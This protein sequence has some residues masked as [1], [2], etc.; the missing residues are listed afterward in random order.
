MKRIRSNVDFFALTDPGLARAQKPNEDA[1]LAC[2]LPEGHL[3]GVA[4]GMGGHKG[5]ARA[6][7]LALETVRRRL[8][9]AADSVLHEPTAL[10]LLDATEQAGR[11]VW[12]EASGELE[13][14]GCT[15]TLL[16]LDDHK[17]MV[18]QVGD[19][20][21]YLFRD[22]VLY[23]LTHDQL[24]THED[25]R[26]SDWERSAFSN[27]LSNA[28]GAEKELRL[29]FF[30]LAVRPRD[31]FL[32]CSDGLHGMLSDDQLH[33]LLSMRLSAKQ[34]AKM[35]VRSADQNGGKDNISAV[36]VDVTSLA[37]DRRRRVEL[38]ETAPAFCVE[39]QAIRKVRGRLTR[40]RD[41]VAL[42][43]SLVFFVV[44]VVGTLFSEWEHAKLFLIAFASSALG[45]LVL[46]LRHSTE[47]ARR[48]PGPLQSALETRA[49]EIDAVQ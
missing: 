31:R 38:F 17:A 40:E 33:L 16:L 1:V 19:S 49:P 13:G 29:C 3:F 35:L 14:M 21:L 22:D 46:W 24:L 4:D 28:L 11:Q 10:N 30:Q 47:A 27:S 48:M 15:L 2:R 8:E 39:P 41:G 9:G 45:A 36:V 37:A 26:L 42:T 20:R 23:R 6:S 43:L 32:L 12:K 18:T 5:G 34:T 25:E 7:M 44:G